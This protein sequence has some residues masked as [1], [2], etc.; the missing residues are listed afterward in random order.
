MQLPIGYDDFG[1]IL[2]H[3]LDF[4]DKTLFIKEV[5]DYK[6]TEAILITRPRRFGKTLNL[7]MLHYFLAPMVYGQPTQ[8][9]F[10]TLKI[11]DYGDHYLQHQGKYPVVSITF[12]DVKEL[13]YPVAQQML[14]KLLARTY[15]EHREL[16]N[17]DAL[18]PH[19]KEAF[20][21]ILE[22]KANESS[23]KMALF[24]LIHLLYL[25]HGVKPWLL[26]DEY[27]TPIQSAHLFKYYGEMIELMRGLFSSALKNNPYLNRAVITGI[28][29]IAKESLFSGLNNLAVYSSLRHEYSEHF[30]FT[31]NEV[32]TILEKSNLSEKA[33]E[34]KHWYNGYQFGGTTIYNPW[35]IA[36]CVKQKGNTEPYWINSSGNELIKELLSNSPLTF[37][38]EFE[39]LMRGEVTEQL[40]DENTVFADLQKS[41][42]TSSPWSLFLMSGYLTPVTCENTWNGQL[43]QLRVPNQ[44]VNNL[45]RQIVVSWL[46]ND[47]SWLQWYRQFTAALVSGNM[48]S[49]RD[50]LEKILL[51]MVSYHDLAKEPEAFFH[52]L[53]LGF[54]AILQDTHEIK[55][56]RES[57]L[58]R[59]DILLVPKDVTQLGIVI[60]L[61]A[62]K[63]DETRSLEAL[64]ETGLT[65]IDAKR[66][67]V[68]LAARG[69][70]RV[71]KI[72]IAFQGK[73][74]ELR[75]AGERE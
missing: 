65:Q 6:N 34:I 48:E 43:C 41:S 33:A 47:E 3:Q 19:Q 50:E 67:T 14:A 55:S 26:I 61:K 22:E 51:Q 37:K 20:G 32:N 42:A 29:R 62:K 73:Q 31:E 60:E 9:L 11:A 38:I 40:I 70:T 68:E 28:L 71:M 23:L 18:T 7:S 72:A 69:I 21:L 16:L 53:L 57:G 27:D 45:Y 8:G 35:S 25:H 58:G 64:A 46:S 17:S 44:E 74:F 5:F 63:P 56:N 54:I 24:D 1:K 66:Y 4:I 10:N 2:D 13:N 12:K 15:F 36:N 52:G 75:Y 49:F 30:G 39:R 59:Y